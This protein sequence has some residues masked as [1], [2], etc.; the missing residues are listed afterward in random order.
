MLLAES[1]QWY[2]DRSSFLKSKEVIQEDHLIMATVAATLKLDV[3][4]EKIK[5]TMG[6]RKE[7]NRKSGA[8]SQASLE[9]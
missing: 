3:I 2:K 9:H 1:Q 8:K 7:P 6:K 5:Q 4:M